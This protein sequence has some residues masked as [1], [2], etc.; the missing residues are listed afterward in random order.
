M[1]WNFFG[2]DLFS[3]Y[4]EFGGKV[5]GMTISKNFASPDACIYTDFLKMQ[6]LQQ[7]A[8]VR[9]IDFFYRWTRSKK[10]LE[11]SM[12]EL[13]RYSDHLKFIFQSNEERINYYMSPLTCPIVVWWQTCIFIPQIVISIRIWLKILHILRI[14]II[15]NQSLRTR[16]LYS[17]ESV[18][19]KHC[20]KCSHG[21]LNKA[22]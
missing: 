9:Y 14:L 2:G 21:S 11:S 1:P 6:N 7:F 3:H 5:S 12:K 13:N 19:S 18:F 10:E 20:N 8:W 17:F 4:F 22:I 15:Y 16:R